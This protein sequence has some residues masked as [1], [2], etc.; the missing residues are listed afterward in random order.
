MLYTWYG[1]YYSSFYTYRYSYQYYSWDNYG[2][3]LVVDNSTVNI[4][5]NSFD[6]NGWVAKHDYWV[7]ANSACFYT[8]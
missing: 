1:Y 3:G 2:Y 8:G 6:S 4:V 7:D 5:S